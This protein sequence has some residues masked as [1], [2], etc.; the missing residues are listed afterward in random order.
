MAADAE[1]ADL[2]RRRLIR[3]QMTVLRTKPF[4]AGAIF[5]TYQDYRTPTHDKMGVVDMYRQ[6]RGSWAVLRE[7]YSPVWIDYVFTLQIIRP[8]GF[9]VVERSHSSAAWC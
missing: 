7:E 3:E 8:T 6:R 9:T 4:V 1:T 5:W 2:Q